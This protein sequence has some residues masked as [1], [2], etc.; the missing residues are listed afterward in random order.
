MSVSRI[1]D[2]GLK[3]S[4][5]HGR[6]VITNK[7]GGVVAEFMRQGGLYVAKMVLKKPT[8][9]PQEEQPANSQSFGRPGQ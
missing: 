9:S 5:D 4:F 6:A 3:A 7:E 2:Q 1:C 8:P